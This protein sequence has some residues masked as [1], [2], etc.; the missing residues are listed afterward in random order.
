LTAENIRDLPHAP[1][2]KRLHYYAIDE[3]HLLVRV[4]DKGAKSL[5]VNKRPAGSTRPLMIKLCTYRNARSLQ[6]ARRRAVDVLKELDAGRHP[7]DA[8]RKERAHVFGEVAEQFIASLHRRGLRRARETEAAVRR[9]FLGQKARP[10]R[11][12]GKR[13]WRTEW[14]NVEPGWRSRELAK[15]DRAAMRERLN[16]IAARNPWAARHAFAAARRLFSYAVERELIDHSPVVGIRSQSLGLDKRMLRRKRVL[17]NAELRA[18]WQAAGEIDSIVYGTLIRVLMLTGQRLSDFAKARRSEIV[19][20]GGLRLLVVPGDRYK[21]GESHETPITP[22]V[23]ELLDQLPVHA[24]SDWLFSVTGAAS[25]SDYSRRKRQLDRLSGVSDWKLHDL[26]RTT[27]T[28]LGTL[29]VA[30]E[31]A[32]RVIGHILGELD[33]VYD[34]GSYRE[35]KNAALIKWETKLMEIVGEP[36]RGLRLVAA[37]ATVA[38]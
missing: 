9:Y 16:A 37:A 18:I 3:P 28:G 19:E 29:G 10:V 38:A 32:E 1:L 22:K 20:D 11:D 14:S 24:G 5:Y 27:R 26:R 23:L 35:Q 13:N 17:T 4:S 21:N 15:L 36:P 33:A 30:R 6:E 34:H 7:R 8:C 2:G 31:V 25:F 12:F